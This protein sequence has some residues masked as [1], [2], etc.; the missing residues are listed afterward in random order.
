M[1][2]CECLAI[3]VLC[4]SGSA[5]G[6]CWPLFTGEDMSVSEYVVVGSCGAYDVVVCVFKSE[7]KDLLGTGRT[8]DDEIKSDC[9]RSSL[10][11]RLFIFWLDCGATLATRRVAIL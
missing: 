7:H 4:A 10:S 2:A 9:A 1:D 6:I 8:L 3:V 11:G 5:W